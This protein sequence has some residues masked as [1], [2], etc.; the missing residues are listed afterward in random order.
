V[1]DA[2]AV[3]VAPAAPAQLPT[4]AATSP[5]GLGDDGE[6]APSIPLMTG[7]QFQ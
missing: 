1:V 4:V 6:L 3:L 7:A 2:R 5:V